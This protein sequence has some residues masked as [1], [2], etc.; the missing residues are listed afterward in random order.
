MSI[1]AIYISNPL[2]WLAANAHKLSSCNWSAR[3]MSRCYDD[4]EEAL[5]HIIE[6]SNKFLDE[7]CMKNTFNRQKEIIPPFKEFLLCKFD[8]QKKRCVQNAD[9]KFNT[10]HSYRVIVKELFEP[11]EETNINTTFL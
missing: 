4:L 6:D 8:L 3:R 9:G 10:V 1:I 2:R 7:D 11:V 5:A